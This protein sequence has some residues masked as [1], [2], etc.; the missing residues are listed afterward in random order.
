MNDIPTLARAARAASRSIAVLPA[1][2]KNAVLHAVANDLVLQCDAILAAN[3]ADVAAAIAADLPKP[4]VQR[5]TLTAQHLTQMAD[6]LRQVAELPDPVGQVTRE[7]HVTSGMLVRRIRAPLGVVCMIYEARPGVTIDA[8][9]LC[10]KAGNACILKG[11]KEAARSNA[12]LAAIAHAALRSHR[13]DPAALTVVSAVSREDLITL[14]QQDASIDLVIPRGGTDL[15]RF[16]ADHSRI[17]TVQHYQG[18]CHAFVDASAD[19]DIAERICLTGK[20]S[21]PATCNALECVLVHRRVAPAFVPRMVATYEKAG[22]QVRADAECLALAPRAWPCAPDDFGREFLDL[23]VA[24][25]IVA[26]LD[27]AVEHIAEYGSNHTEAIITRDQTSADEF[28]RRVQASCTLVNASTRMN[29][30]YSLGL[31]AEI[32]ISTSRVHAYGPMG[33]EELTTQ[34][35]AVVGSGQTR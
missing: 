35:F 9:A 21:A 12:A 15:I 25:R 26:G 10:F 3:S 11:G 14:L 2:I 31:G 27:E 1:S 28:L 13:I 34:R 6:G 30:G 33:L 5:L 19:L 16:V 24:M 4:R 32:G 23:I 20:T 8:F 22:V 18:V 7:Q 29:D 17:P